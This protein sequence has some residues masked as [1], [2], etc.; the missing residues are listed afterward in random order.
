MPWTHPASIQ[1][2][3]AALTHQHQGHE[4]ICLPGKESGPEIHSIHSTKS[5]SSSSNPSVLSIIER[6]ATTVSDHPDP[7]SRPTNPSIYPASSHHPYSTPS[8]SLKPSPYSHPHPS[9]HPHLL[10]PSE[11]TPHFPAEEY[12]ARRRK[13]MMGLEEGSLVICWGGGVKLVSQGEWGK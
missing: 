12:E 1:S 3:P 8:P 11:L 9:T 13:L 2:S 5:L 6:L 7:T 4:Y 10:K